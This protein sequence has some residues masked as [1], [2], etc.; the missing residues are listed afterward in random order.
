MRC[1][2]MNEMASYLD[3]TLSELSRRRMQ[4]HFRTCRMCALALAELRELLGL[5]PIDPGVG[6]T[7]KI[8]ALPVRTR[9]PHDEALNGRMKLAAHCD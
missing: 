6:C 2:D 1:P 9:H 3:A 5:P 7:T 8:K 4:D